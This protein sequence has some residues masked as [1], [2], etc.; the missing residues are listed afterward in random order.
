[1]GRS[2]AKTRRQGLDG[3]ASF[4]AL[5]TFCEYH[6]PSVV[7]STQ[8]L[9]APTTDEIVVAENSAPV[10]DCISQLKRYQIIEED[11]DAD[12]IKIDRTSKL[13]RKFSLQDG[14]SSVRSGCSYCSSL[15]AGLQALVSHGAQASYVSTQV[16][17]FFLCIT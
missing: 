2:P 13:S 15:E 16:L 5:C 17:R 10:Y 8:T 1:M 14:Q 9:D 11:C 7:I 3:M 12:K 4:I 6:G